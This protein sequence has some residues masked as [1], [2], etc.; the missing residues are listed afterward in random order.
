MKVKC[1]CGH[2]NP[3]GT[4]LCEACGKVLDEKDQ[5]QLLVDMRY[6]GSARRSQTYNKTIIDKI[7]NFFSSVKVGVSLIVIT[8]IASALG[9]IFPQEMYIPL[10]FR[11][12]NIIRINMDGSENVYYELGF[13]NLYSSWWYL[14]L[15]ASIGV[16]LVICSLDR[17]IPLYRALKKQKITRHE[18][19]L[20][21][22]RMF[23]IT[24]T[25]ETQNEEAFDQIKE[26]LKAKRYQIR[27]EEWK[28]TC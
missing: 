7:W 1:E 14:L 3:H 13:H 28:H 15:I 17:V 22:Q 8:L 12:R 24:S 2:V 27:E 5:D 21:R 23:G 6:E 25:S 11:L 26:K 4:V 18:G 19:F 10:I 16:S 20:K 9:T